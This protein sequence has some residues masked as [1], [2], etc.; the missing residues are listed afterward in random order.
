MKTA[1][2]TEVA[3]IERRGVDPASLPSNTRYLGLEHIERGGRII[4]SDTV[5]GAELASTKFAFT[6]DHVLYG[7]LRPNLGKVTRPTF[8][9]VCSTDILPIRPGPKL[10]RDYLAHYLSQPA[11]I[12]F[13]ASRTSGANL[14]R[15][16]PTVLGTF[17]IPLP[18]LDEQRRIAAILDRAVELCA[19]RRKVTGNLVAL[20]QANF[21]ETFGDP[22]RNEMNWPTGSLGQQAVRIT[23]GEHKTPLR[24]QSGI[25]LLSARSVQRGW[26]DFSAT[27][28]I[29]EDTY[30]TLRRRIE[31]QDGDVLI[32]CSGTIGRV[33]RVSGAQR[34]AMVRSV[35]LVRP[36]ASLSPGFLQQLLATDSLNA[37][38]NVRANSSAQANLFQNQIRDLPVIVPPIA[39]QKSFEEQIEAVT[40]LRLLSTAAL[41][42]LVEL[43]ASLQSRAFSG[44]L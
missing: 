14:P 8:A 24:T 22:I 18:P 32:S 23:D 41:A 26:I 39:L 36:G 29:G 30:E 2:L 40:Q 21:I 38:M 35:A 43:T 7:K 34:F 33:A 16:S 25:P 15:I 10:D 11:T 27:D 44:Q 37:L 4:G 42:K 28:H 20:E 3:T 12:D 31:P 19:M 1:P 6:P 17:E 9:G 13:A 5:G